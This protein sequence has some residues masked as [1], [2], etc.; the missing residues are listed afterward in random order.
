LII[1]RPKGGDQFPLG[2]RDQLVLL[3]ARHTVPTTYPQR[4]YVDAGG[5]ISCGTGVPNG[6]RQAGVYTGRTLR[7]AKPAE[8]PLLQLTKLELVINLKTARALGLSSR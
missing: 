3:A 1:C 5:L 7:G 8:L 6:Y 4:E 2:Q